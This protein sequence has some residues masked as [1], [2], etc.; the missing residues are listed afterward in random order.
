MPHPARSFC[1]ASMILG[2]L[3]ARCT[4]GE[5][6]GTLEIKVKDHREA[7]EDFRSLEITVEEIR[8]NAASENEP[9]E[10]AWQ[11][12]SPQTR[13]VDL[14][15]FTGG[16]AA[17]LFSG[18]L[19]QRHFDAI[20]LRLGRIRGLLKKTGETARVQNFVGPIRLRFSVVPG[21]K[22][23]VVLDLAVIDMRDHPGRGYEL[24]IKG[25]ELFAEGTLIDR[26]PPASS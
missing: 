11:V 14:T 10:P 20:D 13:N 4:A 12:V 3:L 22:T 16:D 26:V 8:L 5:Q 6:R 25:Y 2:I 23:A 1:L 9:R 24:R 18:P 19:T 17:T 7:I 21:E 15:L